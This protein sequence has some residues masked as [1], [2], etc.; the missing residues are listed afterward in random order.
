MV[1]RAM[2]KQIGSWAGFLIVPL[3]IAGAIYLITYRRFDT[4]IIIDLILLAVAVILYATTNPLPVRGT[5]GKQMVGSSLSALIVC[6]AAVGIIVLINILM[7]RVTLRSDLTSTQQFSVTSAT[8]DTLKKIKDPIT[9]TVFYNSDPN[10]GGDVARQQIADLLKE[11]ISR[12][13]KLN[14]VYVDAN[15]DPVKVRDFNIAALPTVVFQ[16]G[17]RRE[18]V[19][20]T[21]EQSFTRAILRVQSEVQRRVFFVTGHNEP[22]IT[23]TG[24][25][26]SFSQAAQALKDNNYKVDTINLLNFSTSGT[27]TNTTNPNEPLKLN[28]VSD[29]L[30]F[31]APHAPFTDA[32]KQNALSF[33]RQGGKALFMA[34]P[35]NGTASI[36]A[37]QR[38]NLNDLLKEWNLQMPYGLVVE[39]DPQR[40]FSSPIVLLPQVQTGS[41]ITRNVPD[42]RVFVA[43]STQVMQG[44]DK[45]ASEGGT[46]TP[47]LQSS[48]NSYFRAD[49]Q[50]LGQAF[51]P[52]KDT[53]GPLTVAATYQVAAKEP[54]AGTQNANTR[55][56]LYGSYL[57]ASDDRTVGIPNGG[58][59]FF[60]INTMNWLT[61]LNDSVVI[62]PKD[63]GTQPF[64]VSESQGSFLFWST[65]LGL[66]IL[67]LFVGIAVW[68]RRR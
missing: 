25:G 18:D 1:N 28:P 23:D 52:A 66:P 41:D 55:I 11:Y 50:N 56:A 53:R 30:V 22:S 57:M 65:F 44:Q 9:V 37:A 27:I 39:L 40:R 35:L 21:D 59:Y 14:V 34:D 32:E 13:D 60:F 16:Q 63:A 19:T 43:Q 42:G 51:D 36:P 67:V 10:S 2:L 61:E 46:F 15:A 58:N 3:V 33:L 7:Q 5:L 45:A 68:W 31:G 47:L 64:A 6:I 4:P 17:Q 54:P 49:L 29:V 62:A 20:S 26:D 48:V 24:T 38:D 8:L 12:T